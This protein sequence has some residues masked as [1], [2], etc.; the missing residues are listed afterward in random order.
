M[1]FSRVFCSSL[2]LLGLWIAA[3]PDYD[4]AEN[5]QKHQVQNH[6]VDSGSGFL[7]AHLSHRVSFMVSNHLAQPGHSTWHHP[8]FDFELKKA[9]HVLGFG[10][11][12]FGTGLYPAQGPVPTLRTST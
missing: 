11:T 6:Q 2:L 5:E 9:F 10:Q 7:T 1:L 8:R 3:E 4:H 12:S